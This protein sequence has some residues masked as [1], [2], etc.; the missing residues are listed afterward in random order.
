MSRSCPYCNYQFDEHENRTGETNP[1]NGD[2]SFCIN[3]GQV[4][5][6]KEGDIIKMDFGNLDEDIKREIK[7]LSSA[8]IKLRDGKNVAFDK[9]SQGF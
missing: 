2:I 9:F 4:G 6:F 5:E 7:V 1:S 8:W 3:C